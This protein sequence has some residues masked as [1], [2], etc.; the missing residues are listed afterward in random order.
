MGNLPMVTPKASRSSL[1][2]FASRTARVMN[3]AAES[4]TVSRE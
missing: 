2:F 4:P 1:Y 3:A